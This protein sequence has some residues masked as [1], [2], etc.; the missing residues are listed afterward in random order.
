MT[1]HGISQ[2]AVVSHERHGEKRWR[3]F[4]GYAFAA[5]DALAPVAGAE[6]ARAALSMPLAFAEQS[7]RYT[8][9]A[10][11]SLT[12]GRNMFVGADGSWLGSYIPAW[13][14][15]H[16]FRLIPREGTGEAVLCVDEG[17]G[18]VAEGSSAGEAFFDQAGKLSPALKPVLDLMTQVE[19]S[20]KATDLAVLALAQAG[21]V[22]PWQ[23][24][25]K[26]EQGAQAIGGLHRIDEA[27]LAALPD[28]VFLKLRTSSALPIA[29][30]QILSAG[31]LGIFERLARVQAPLTPPPAASLPESLDSF[32]AL[33]SDD[34]I[35][36]E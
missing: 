8:L 12:A 31:Q 32:F 11:L 17:S 13:Y 7:G 29:Y 25:V 26:T 10:V 30:A 36:F 20:R 1:A 5:T 28:D 14:R 19:R 2:F 18:L 33:P 15:A 9:V 4:S 21:V 3:R 6:L 23:I 35:R 16:P 27:A 34:M 22:R 24:T